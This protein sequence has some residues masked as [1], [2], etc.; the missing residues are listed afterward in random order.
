[1]PDVVLTPLPISPFQ[2]PEPGLLPG[3]P[4]GHFF[5]HLKNNSPSWF[6]AFGR[7][8]S[9]GPAAQ[10]RSLPLFPQPLAASELG[11]DLSPARASDLEDA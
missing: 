4:T 9:G 10:G 11:C 8:E 5:T 7:R 2:S 3:K 1:M 6:P